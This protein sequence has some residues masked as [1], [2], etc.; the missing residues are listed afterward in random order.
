ML[1][2]Y[3]MSKLIIVLDCGATNVRAIAINE[4]GQ[5]VAQE[6]IFNAT[7]KDPDYPDYL[8]WDT[9]EIWGKF[10][11]CCKSIISKINTNEIVGVTVT[12]FGVDGAPVDANGKLIHPVISWQCSRTSPVMDNIGKYI[13]L[14]DL[15]Q[16]NGVQPFSFNTINKLIWFKEN[17]PEIVEK[18]DKYMFISSIFIN[19]LC[20]EMITEASMAGT[21]MLTDVQEQEFSDKILSKIGYEKSIFPKMVQ[22]GDKVGTVNETAMADLGIPSGVEVFA[23]GHDTQYAIFGSGAELNEPVLSSGTWEILMARTSEVNLEKLTTKNGITIEFGSKPKHYNIGCQW[24]A[25]G[26]LEWVKK[27]FYADKLEDEDIYDIMINGAREVKETKVKFENDFSFHSNSSG[28]ISGL[29][30]KTERAEIYRACLEYLSRRL[31]DSLSTLEET[32]NFKANS[33][34]CVGGGSKNRLWNQIKADTLGIPVKTI[35][36]KETTVLGA[37]LYAFMGAGVYKSAE[38]ARQNIDYKTESFIPTVK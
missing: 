15:Y 9:E 31:K 5:I 27:T 16:I 36:Q 2:A 11:K 18:M 32:A 37:A 7:T 23:A 8:I 19:K 17:R 10:S 22:S 3:R 28:T 38:E 14:E 25:S 34:I 13:D 20:G 4:K 12:T 33:I 26:V 21:S 29:T 30:I 6:S 35:N 24:L 1:K